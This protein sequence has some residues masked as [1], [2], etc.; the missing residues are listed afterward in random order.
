MKLRPWW[1][2]HPRRYW[3]EEDIAE[4]VK[5]GKPKIPRDP[6]FERAQR[7]A[8]ELRASQPPAPQH[9]LV[10]FGGLHDTQK[11]QRTRARGR[12]VDALLTEYG[13]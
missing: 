11:Q 2:T 6:I 12:V 8:K 10:G 5:A 7:R 3:H 13:L 4:W 1:E 9:T